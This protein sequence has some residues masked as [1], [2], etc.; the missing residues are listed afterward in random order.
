MRGFKAASFTLSDKT[1][2]IHGPAQ[3]GW[4]VNRNRIRLMDNP[5]L[6]IPAAQTT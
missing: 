5:P 2:M 4:T 6:A 1:V 3:T